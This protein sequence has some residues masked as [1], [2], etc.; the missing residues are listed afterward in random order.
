[1]AT[2]EPNNQRSLSV[3]D[4][5]G[6]QQTMVLDEAYDDGMDELKSNAEQAVQRLLDIDP[7]DIEERRDGIAAVEQM[8]V[9]L[10]KKA[11]RRSMMLKQSIHVLAKTG[12]D[13]GPVAGSLI[14]L[15]TK[16]EELDPNR[17]D[18]SMNWFRRL[19]AML[20]FVGTP[21]SNYFSRYQSADAVLG[22][23]VLSL[24]RGRD[25]LK[26]DIITLE[27]DQQQMYGLIEAL[28]KVIAYG[29][30]IDR[31]LTDRID[32]ELPDDDPKAGFLQEEIVFPLRQRIM[33]LQQQLN[34]SQQAVL[35]IEIINRNNKELI[36]GVS[37]ALSVTVSA[38]QVAITLSLALANQ[39]IVLDKI[40]AVNQT[41]DSLIAR[42]AENLKTQGVAIHKQAAS[43]QLS[44][45]TL[46]QSFADIQAALNDIAAFRRDALPQMARSI[47]EMDEMAEAATEVIDKM[48]EGKQI[49]Q[50]YG[51]EIFDTADQDEPGR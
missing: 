19:I 49:Q 30:W 41:T 8:A 17:F 43:T 39:K 14:E 31:T 21:V 4:M 20:P 22:D 35:T 24:E 28:K 5:D 36:R 2:P 48:D 23:I 16:V 27:D 26:R 29:R 50:E 12:D 7:N 47:L 37:R 3:P 44:M 18:L 40:E 32:N 51:L 15:R 38:L 6:L 46:K 34:V 1:M 42:T 13:G 33:D 45:D 11:A 9:G 10:Q 25:Q